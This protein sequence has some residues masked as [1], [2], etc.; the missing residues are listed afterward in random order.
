METAIAVSLDSL[1]FSSY[2]FIVSLGLTIIF[3]VMKVLNIAHGGVC[4]WGRVRCGVFGA[5]CLLAGFK[6]PHWPDHVDPRS[7]LCAR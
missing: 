2:L 7:A 5:A 6:A 4:A 1:T 3:G